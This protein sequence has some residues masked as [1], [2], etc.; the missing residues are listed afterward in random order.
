MVSQWACRATVLLPHTGNA[1]CGM[2]SPHHA[3]NSPPGVALGYPAPSP[4][5]PHFLKENK[6]LP[7]PTSNPPKPPNPNNYPTKQIQPKPTKSNPKPTPKN[8]YFPPVKLLPK[9]S[10]RKTNTYPNPHPTNHQTPKPATPTLSK[11]TYP[12]PKDT[13][14][15]TYP[16]KPIQT[17]RV[18]HVH[19]GIILHTPLL[20]S[21]PTY[22]NQPIL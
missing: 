17:T 16:N 13:T 14:Y 3:P 11:Q 18:T 19:K 5:K 22:P 10:I 2:P 15:T 6:Y 8:K 9:R 7:Q 12:N 21:K 1:G 4:T 20:L